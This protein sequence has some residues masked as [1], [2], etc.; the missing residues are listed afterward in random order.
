MLERIRAVRPVGVDDGHGGGE[1]LFALVMVGD[2]K[3]DA[4]RCGVGGLINARDA[5]VD[6]DDQRDAGLGKGADGVAAE[7]VALFDAAGDMQGHIRAA[8]AE[9]IGEKTGGGDAVHIIVAKDGDL[10][11]AFQR[12]CDA[13]YG[14]VHVLH[15]KRRTGERRFTLERFGGLFT[16]LHAARGQHR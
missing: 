10:F 12:P 1:L 9:I 16:R 13:G 15:Q 2:D 8:G 11:A 7:T 14:F 5:A 3:I 4:E 6:R